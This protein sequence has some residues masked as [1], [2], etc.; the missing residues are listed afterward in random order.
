MESSRHVSAHIDRP[1][2]DVY[3]YASDPAN[4]PAWAPG[5][6]TSI[7]PA[8]GGVWVAQ[9]PMGRIFV[10]YA[11]RNE[12]GVLDHDVTL[13]SGETVHNPVRVIPAG[14]GSEIVFSLRRR[15][16][17]SDDEFERDAQAV[18]ADLV[19]LKRLVES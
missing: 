2:R 15:P 19:A 3:D 1:V 6:C 10:A 16:G 13:E 14:D 7:E 8:D 11:P 17:M 18:H 9:S 5:L 4:L 12:F